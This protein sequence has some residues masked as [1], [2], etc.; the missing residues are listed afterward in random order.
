M[1]NPTKIPFLDLIT[2]HQELQAELL[3]VVQKVFSDASFIG[4]P[5]VEEF[6]HEFAAFCD[7]KYCVGVN[8]GTDALRF[9]LM[10]AGVQPGDM[11]SLFH[12]HL[13]R[14]R[15]R[16]LRPVRKSLLSTSMN[17]AIRWIRRSSTNLLRGDVNS[18][19]ELEN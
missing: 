18:I 14:Q 4:G 11:V 16:F 6:E 7:A 17:R 15:K 9:A 12:T 19:A 5:M 2:P 3:A 13:L 1:I 8:S 10:A